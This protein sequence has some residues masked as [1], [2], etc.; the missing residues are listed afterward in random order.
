M[1]TTDTTFQREHEFI[2][3]RE[4]F[5]ITIASPI[6][7]DTIESIARKDFIWLNRPDEEYI[8]RYI[9]KAVLEQSI[10]LQEV[11]EELDLLAFWKR[12]YPN[13]PA[14]YLPPNF[15]Y[16]HV[17]YMLYKKW[18]HL[19]IR[20][21]GNAP[22]LYAVYERRK[23]A[24]GWFKSYY[25]NVHVRNDIAVPGNFFSEAHRDNVEFHVK[26]REFMEAEGLMLIREVKQK[27][28]DE[29]ARENRQYMQ[30]KNRRAL[31]R[32]NAEQLR[33]TYWGNLRRIEYEKLE[34]ERLAYEAQKQKKVE[35]LRLH[36]MSQSNHQENT[37]E[38]E[39]ME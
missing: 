39:S 31:V 18:G 7:R 10:Y 23:V 28:I 2:L 32:E 9:T 16:T 38:N 19:Y 25:R 15:K 13:M 8:P 6:A 37:Q 34:A 24:Q 3:A 4:A 22:H 26:G 14:A 30:I 1:S 5:D 27:R 12:V 20:Y 11:N 35:A 33:D 36:I 21:A 17:V 29:R